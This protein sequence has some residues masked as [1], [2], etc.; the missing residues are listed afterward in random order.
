MKNRELETQVQELEEL[1][2][3]KLEASAGHSGLQTPTLK[4]LAAH[5]PS[6]GT[7]FQTLTYLLTRED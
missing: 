4:G 2:D 3:S 6:E 5:A 1:Q 7:S